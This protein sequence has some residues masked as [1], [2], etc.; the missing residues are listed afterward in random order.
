MTHAEIAWSYRV[1]A[2]CIKKKEMMGHDQDHDDLDKGQSRAAAEIAYATERRDIFHNL[3]S[4]YTM[5][6]P[7][8]TSAHALANLDEISGNVSWDVDRRLRGMNA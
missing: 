8:R 6:S 7:A 4:Y 2:R 5:Q 3:S 1:F